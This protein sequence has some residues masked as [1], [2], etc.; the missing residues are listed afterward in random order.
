MAESQRKTSSIRLSIAMATCNGA[1]FLLEQLNSLSSQTLLPHELVICDDCSTDGTVR[2]LKQFAARA[3]F[4]VHIHKNPQRLGFGDNFLKTASICKGDWILF[5]DQDDSWLPDKLLTV[6]HAIENSTDDD[7]ML[8]THSALLT[9]TKLNPIDGTMPRCSHDHT[10]GR[11]RHRGFWVV[12]GFTCAFRRDLMASFDW[13]LRPPSYDRRHLMQPHDK[14]ICMLANAL[15]SVH[16]I[17]KPLALYRRHPAALTGTY[18][19]T[20]V[21]E[22]IALSTKVGAD[23]YNF[24][25]GVARQSS[26]TLST[27]ARTANNA[28]WGERL[29]G[30][31]LLFQRLART[32]LSRAKIYQETKWSAR[33]LG[34]L[35]LILRRGYL[36]SR[37]YS[38][39]MPSLLKDLWYCLS[40]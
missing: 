40:S 14:W 16:Y 32:Y 31:A 12:P 28:T 24:L 9:D 37:F 10:I 38:L 2:L 23:H 17:S 20:S 29:D 22:K 8:V 30:S 11:S 6:C 36:G 1:D 4:S 19:E 21:R 33:F 5:C 7:L 25:V 13:K 26:E 27:L 3:P 39:G 15:G 34:L 35:G 18:P